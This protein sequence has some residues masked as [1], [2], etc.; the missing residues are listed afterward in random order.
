G[1]K[2]LKGSTAVI[3]IYYIHRDPKHFSDPDRFDP[4]RFL[5]ENS[6]DRSSFAF[7]PFSAGSRNCIGQRFAMLEE[8]S[9]LSWI[10]RRYK[11]KTSQT[12]DDLH[13]SFEIILRSEHG[14]FVQLEHDMTKNSIEI[15]FSENIEI[16][17]PKC[18]HGPTL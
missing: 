2:V 16:N 14:A 12:R 18:V 8:K 1:Y 15:D 11:L 17:H 6:H 3:F 13:L 5:P 10:L 9:M 4:D 7:V